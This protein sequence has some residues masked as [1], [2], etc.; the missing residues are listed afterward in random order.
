V[1]SK[2]CL[3]CSKNNFEFLS[4]YLTFTEW[5]TLYGGRR[6]AAGHN[7]QNAEFRRLPFDHCSLSLQPFEN[8]YCDQHG[9]I[10][11][12]MTLLPFLKRFKINPITGEKLDAK[13]LTKLN[14]TKN[15]DEQYHCPVLYKVFNQNTHIVAV[16]TTGNI[17]SYDVSAV[18]HE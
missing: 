11:D 9:N 15:A 10:F 6:A 16:K 12:L 7:N 1:K 2:K 14:F 18:H 5:S 8:P 4:R 17:F 13:Q 3:N